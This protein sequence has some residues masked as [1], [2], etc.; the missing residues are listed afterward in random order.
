MLMVPSTVRIF[1]A[2]G[3]TDLRRS[4]DGL[5][6]LTRETIQ[7]DP[8]SGHLFVFRNRRGDRVKILFWHKNGFCLWYKRLETGVFRFPASAD[9]RKV[10]VEATDLAL[11]LEGVDSTRVPRAP[12][13]VPG[14]GIVPGGKNLADSAK[15]VL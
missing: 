3:P 9:G 15:K 2:S 12:R 1:L 4:F 14:R 8:F 5:A 7:Q 13:F 6:L 11:L 10:E